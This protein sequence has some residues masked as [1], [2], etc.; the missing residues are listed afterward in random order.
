MR[1]AEQASHTSA[2]HCMQQQ[3]LATPSQHLT[4]RL[5]WRRS[6]RF[7][8]HALSK[9]TPSPKP[10][11]TLYIQALEEQ[12]AYHT[13]TTLTLTTLTLTTLTTLTPAT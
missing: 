6:S 3:A 8:N 5:V 11:H 10:Q 4:P 13:L 1:Q 2:T 7:P 12:Q 9:A